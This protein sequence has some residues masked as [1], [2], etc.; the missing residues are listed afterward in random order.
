MEISLLI[1]WSVREFHNLICVHEIML[2]KCSCVFLAHHLG[3]GL[4]LCFSSVVQTYRNGK[5]I[6]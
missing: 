1:G 2:L 6:L 3:K 5:R 4:K